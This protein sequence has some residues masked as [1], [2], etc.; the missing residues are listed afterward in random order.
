MID[1]YADR[2]IHGYLDQALTPADQAEFESLMLRS[3]AARSRFWALAEVHGLA[4]QAALVAWPDLDAAPQWVE[5]VAAP[6]ERRS[7][8]RSR[9]SALVLAAGFF[10]GILITGVALPVSGMLLSPTRTSLLYEDFES[11]VAPKTS[12]M[13]AEPGYWSGDFSE[14][15]ASHQGVQ[16]P[17]GDKMLRILR[18]DYEGKP[19][20]EGSYCGDLLRLID[21]RPYRK[22]IGDGNALVSA[23]AL[24]NTSLLPSNEEY[25]YSVGIIALPAEAA[26]DAAMLV[27]PMAE[28]YSL[29]MTR[30]NLPL[31]YDPT[32]WQQGY[33]EL[34][35]S[36]D[37]DFLLIHISVTYGHSPDSIRRISFA[38]HY[39][40]DIHVT[41]ANYAR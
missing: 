22:Q 25:R 39:I 26:Q 15:V 17:S 9:K 36:P 10:L 20:P 23:T 28:R 1:E 29:A 24:F 37:V 41:L 11:G 12:G 31:D 38:G 3:E 16:P 27:A 5:R 4:P 21:L 32:T 33:S 35:L 19:D 14:V 8:I 40:D 34:K 6:C 7:G 2:L 13:P 30:E 18:A